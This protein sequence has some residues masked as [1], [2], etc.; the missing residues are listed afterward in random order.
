MQSQ[1]F[2]NTSL[3]DL[4]TRKTEFYGEVYQIRE[5]V[6]ACDYE[7]CFKDKDSTEQ[8]GVNGSGITRCKIMYS[9][10]FIRYV[11]MVC[12]QLYKVTPIY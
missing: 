1:K 10:Y 3:A 8:N 11:S 12:H 5:K 4:E 6:S 2:L 9:T 7:L